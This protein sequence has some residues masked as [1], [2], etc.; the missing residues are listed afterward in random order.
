M[1][2]LRRYQIADG[3]RF[4]CERF[5]IDPA[6]GLRRAGLP[7]DFLE[8]DARPVTA[9]EYYAIWN[10]LDAEAP[11]PKFPKL[12]AEA[13]SRGEFD[14]S[15]YAFHSSPTVRIGL[16]RKAILKSLIMPMSMHVSSYDTHLVA[17]F[18][19]VL[20]EDPLPALLGWFNLTYF[21]L[22]IREATGVH[23]RPAAIEVEELRPGWADAE[24]LF[25]CPITQGRGY[26]L[27]L[28]SEDADLPLI[29]RN[30][31]L[32]DRVE[33]GL[34]ERFVQEIAPK[35]TA[36]RVRQALVEGLPGGQ[37]T[38]D[39]IAR[40][41]AL[42]KRSLQRRLSEEGASF[43]DV[44]EDTRRALALSYLQNST[45]SI[46]EIALLL[47][48]RDRTSFFRAFRSWTG[49]TPKSVRRRSA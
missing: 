33:A 37:V 38:I 46:E 48:F 5:G 1:T 6:R 27:V 10:G 7:P 40:K 24:A 29:T 13:F 11:L 34:A 20:P 32:A 39:Q 4:V 23:V 42:S 30:D 41:L 14:S 2:Q 36:A 49:Q 44:L 12:L 9:Q 8:A 16:Q 3:M 45:M 47:G 35:S 26:R 18:A 21:T 22:S 28:K 43:K 25:G 17:S 15:E 19:S 31:A